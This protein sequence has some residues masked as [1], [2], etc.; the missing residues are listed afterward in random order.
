[1]IAIDGEFFR[2]DVDGTVARIG[3]GERTPFAV[4]IAFEPTVDEQLGEQATSHEALLARL[5]ELA[6]PDASS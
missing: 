4:I 1:M 6:P 3:L 5:D 2:A